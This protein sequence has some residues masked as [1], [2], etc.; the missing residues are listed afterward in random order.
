MRLTTNISYSAHFLL[1]GGKRPVSRT[2]SEAHEFDIREASAD[3]A[4]IAASW[5]Q[6]VVC[7]ATRFHVRTFEGFLYQP[8]N[9]A[10]G[11]PEQ[12]P[13]TYIA[14]LQLPPEGGRMPLDHEIAHRLGDDRYEA[15]RSTTEGLEGILIVD[16][17]PY[18]RCDIPR[19]AVSVADEGFS[20]VKMYTGWSHQ[21]THAKAGID[22]FAFEPLSEFDTVV[23]TLRESGKAVHTQLSD[24]VVAVPEA[25]YFDKHAETF[26][27]VVGQAIFDNAGNLYTLSRDQGHEFLDIRDRYRGWLK[28][29]G[30]ED[31]VRLLDRLYALLVDTGRYNQG[32]VANFVMNYDR[33]LEGLADAAISIDLAPKP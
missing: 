11:H 24:V 12:E 1:T 28:A 17:F 30:T 3:E 21:E 7:V 15:V 5:T 2:V 16:G 10:A 13:E 9:Q 33:A 29:P 8:H 6:E 14:S 27:R 20:Y 18:V 26:G 31:P 23:E 19:L 25:L 22:E 32:K 4:P